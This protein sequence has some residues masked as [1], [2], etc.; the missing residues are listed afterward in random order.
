MGNVLNFASKVNTGGTVNVSG[1][2]LWLVA[3]SPA[4][5]IADNMARQ[6]NGYNWNSANSTHG[7]L[8]RNSGSSLTLTAARYGSVDVS[9]TS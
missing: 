7:L 4:A 5:F 9:G 8:A 6:I 2:N 3:G 1:Y